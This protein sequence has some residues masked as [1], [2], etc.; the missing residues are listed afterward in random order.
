MFGGI[1]IPVD[2]DNILS[3]FKPEDQVT[4]KAL[5]GVK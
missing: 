4:I 1:A 3:K 2:V 5:A